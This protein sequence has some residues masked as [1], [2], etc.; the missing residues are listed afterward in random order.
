[1][2]PRGKEFLFFSF[3]NIVGTT[4]SFTGPI[5]SSAIIDVSK[6][7]NNS[8]PFYFLTAI[9]MA[10]FLLVVFFVDLDKSRQEQAEFLAEEK[11][12][13]E[14]LA[15]SRRGSEDHSSS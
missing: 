14:S 8:L 11:G 13:K 2:T 9:A 10:S 15:A 5:I 1:M 4:T 3:F 6:S 7:K 12:I